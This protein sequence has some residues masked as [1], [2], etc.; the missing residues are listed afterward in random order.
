MTQHGRSNGAGR[1]GCQ[2][3]IS[4]PVP[5]CNRLIRENKAVSIRTCKLCISFHFDRKLKTFLYLELKFPDG[6]SVK[7]NGFDHASKN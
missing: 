3:F 5:G 7:D 2:K 4:T 6:S 1:A